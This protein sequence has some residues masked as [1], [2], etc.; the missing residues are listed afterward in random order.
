MKK[1]RLLSYRLD[2]SQVSCPGGHKHLRI[3]G[4][5][6]KPSAVYVK[7]LAQRFATVFRD[8]LKRQAQETS[9]VLN[10][11]EIEAVLANDVLSTGEWKVEVEWCGKSPSHINILESHAYLTLL[12][13]LALR[14]GNRRFSALLDSQVAKSSHAKGR[15]S[16]RALLPTIKKAAAI[17][18]ACG[19]YSSLNFAPIRLNVADD[20]LI[21]E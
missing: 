5:Y 10:K 6:T 16:S 2:S 18:A 21:L 14:C 17:Q 20:P 7:R 11:P 13:R 4:K 9:S 19:L 12:K 1:F 15:S 8:A 3:E